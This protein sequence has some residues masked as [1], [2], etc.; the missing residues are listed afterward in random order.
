MA[1]SPQV[2][3][4]D[5]MNLLVRSVKAGEKMPNLSHEGVSTGALVAFTGT[6]VRHLSMAPWDYVLISWEGERKLNWRQRFYPEY[7][8][9]RPLHRDDVPLMSRDQELAMEFCDAAG[10]YQSWQSDME[11]DDI[12]AAAWRVF[13]QQDSCPQITVVTE[14]RDLLQLCEVNTVW[15]AWSMEITTS[16]HV[17]ETYMVRPARLPLLRALAGDP[18]DGIPGIKGIGTVTAANML[19]DHASDLDVI[20]SL[21]AK[22]G[23]QP[24][25]QVFVWWLIS[26]LRNPVVEPRLGPADELTANTA[27]HPG[28]H[29]GSM[30]D[31]LAKYGMKRLK[32]RLDAG[33]LPWSLS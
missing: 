1:E 2:L 21:A 31:F 8:S 23:L 19:D 26:D 24:M 27:W 33:D 6:L 12:L 20:R 25:M 15:R 14:D 22:L 32:A 5:G 30:L 11:G 3:L 10:I 18:A 4:L 29:T 13:R 7:K 28:E 16:M 9:N 17:C